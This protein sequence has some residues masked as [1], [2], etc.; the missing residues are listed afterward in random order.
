MA[1]WT[2]PACE[3]EFGVPGQSHTCRPGLSVAVLL[4][5]HPEWVGD[6]HR[7][8][9]AELQGLGPVHEDAVEVGIFLKSDHKF[10]EFRPLVRSA[11]LAIYLP[12]LIEDDRFRRR[13]SVGGGRYAH[14]LALTRP[15]QVDR[16]VRD[17]L[18]EAY[19]AATG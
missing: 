3:R 2:C 17:W 6:I 14:V 16:A 4:A 18:S 10:A 9:I 1:R 15:E 7:V 13:V 5:R 8:V 19:L 11:R 12:R